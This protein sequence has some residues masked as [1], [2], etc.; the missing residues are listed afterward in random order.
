MASRNRQPRGAVVTMS[1]G[2]A[3]ERACMHPQTIRDYE[4]RG[5][6]SPLRTEGGTRRYRD[7]D[8]Q[9]LLRIQQLTELGL[10]LSGVEL[11]LRLEQEVDGLRSMVR[12]LEDRLR[13]H[14]ER[15]AASTLDRTPTRANGAELVSRRSV[16]VEIVHVPRRRRSARWKN[17]E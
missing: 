13:A 8:I 5:L 4:R 17:V 6:I 15:T 14:G 16:S 1:I 3:A 11:V 2:A 9:Q 10:S 7:H 12:S